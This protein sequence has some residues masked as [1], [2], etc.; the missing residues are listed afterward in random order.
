ME[1]LSTV[2]MVDPSRAGMEGPRQVMVGLREQDMVDPRA[3]MVGLRREVT[4]G[5]RATSQPL[6]PTLHRE[7]WEDLDSSRC[8]QQVKQVDCHISCTSF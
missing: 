8:V 4:V 1:D 5:H 7:A 3:D 6:V 2:A